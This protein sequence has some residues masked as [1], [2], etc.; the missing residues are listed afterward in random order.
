MIEFKVIRLERHVLNK[1]HPMWKACDELCLQSKNMYN[2]CNYTIRQE[3]FA[4][5]KVMSYGELN[6]LL[7][8]TDAFKELGSNSAQM[9]T[10]ILC[11]T[12]KSFLVAVKDYSM[13]PDKY[14]GK[15]RIPNYKKKDGRFICTLT[16]CQTGIID[17]Y[18][19]L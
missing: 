8:I 6:K 10:Q 2:V 15:P 17:G 16:N 14:L 9:V 3:F 12:W 19:H 1:G 11:N 7:K 13:H 5:K 4:T 18:L